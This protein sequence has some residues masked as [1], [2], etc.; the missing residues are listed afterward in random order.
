MRSALLTLP[1]SAPSAAAERDARLRAMV[2]EHFD[3]TWRNAVRLGVPRADADDA[4]QQVFLVAA[5][6]LDDIAVGDE[7]AFLFGACLRIAARHRRTLE[8]RRE[9]GEPV[10][11]SL[12]DP[13]ADPHQ[14][15]ERRRAREQ[16]DRVLDALPLE[17]R[18]VFVLYELEEETMASIAQTLA[19]P[20]GTVASRLRRAREAFSVTVK[21]LN[22]G[23]AR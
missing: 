4:A 16:L 15:C 9:S 6:R 13:S 1:W 14:L 22:E 19:I 3:F 12:A 10:S 8:R 23:E 18:S 11:A 21:A 7:R 17:L 5:G 2:A 20:P